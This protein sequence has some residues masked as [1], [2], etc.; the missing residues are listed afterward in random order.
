M[1]IQ[2]SKK[3]CRFAAFATIFLLIFITGIVGLSSAQTTENGNGLLGNG[4]INVIWGPLTLIVPIVIAYIAFRE[5]KRLLQLVEDIAFRFNQ[6]PSLQDQ[7]GT[8]EDIINLQKNEDPK[9]LKRVQRAVR[10][11]DRSSKAS[12]PD[13]VIAD[14]Y[15][16][17]EDENIDE[18]IK[19]WRD[20][21]IDL[22]GTDDN[23]AAEAWYSVGYLYIRKLEEGSLSAD[24]KLGAIANAVHAYDQAIRLN[25]DYAEAYCKRGGIKSNWGEYESALAD[26]DAAIDLNREY[27]EAYYN[28]GK[29]RATLG[30]YELALE[31]YNA[32]INLKSDYAE[33]YCERG[34][35]KVKL[36]DS[37]KALDD[38]NVAPPSKSG[39][40][41]SLLQPR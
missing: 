7:L 9:E 15:K 12:A 29:V 33:A 34:T 19:R 25:R 4:I 14:I 13:K 18:A 39:V 6:S 28:R 16:L 30:E 5:N 22:E 8:S 37:T 27:T 35:A 1:T 23:R 41:R 3:R 24:D 10:N 32:A 2:Y 31:D 11:T 21:A 20:R 38:Y 26:Y 40:Y 17:H 36:G